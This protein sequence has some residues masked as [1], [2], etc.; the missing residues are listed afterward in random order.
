[1]KWESGQSSLGVRPDNPNQVCEYVQKVARDLRG[2]RGLVGAEGG[3]GKR[4]H[5][6]VFKSKCILVIKQKQDTRIV[7]HSSA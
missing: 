6:K 3:A 2:S 7:P 4:W 1:M 5:L